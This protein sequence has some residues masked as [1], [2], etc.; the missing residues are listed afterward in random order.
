MPVQIDGE[1]LGQTPVS[2]RV[3]PQTI[4]VVAPQPVKD[5]SAAA[6]PRPSPATT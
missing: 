2:I 4:R 3:H 5:S 1:P 6:T